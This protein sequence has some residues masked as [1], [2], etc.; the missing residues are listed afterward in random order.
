MPSLPEGLSS[1]CAPMAAVLRW[2]ALSL[3]IS[4]LQNQ[5]LDYL[6]AGY[7]TWISNHEKSLAE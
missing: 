7:L 3:T 1:M 5:A 4:P 6:D 2:N